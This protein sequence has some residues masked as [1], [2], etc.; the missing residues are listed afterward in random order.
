MLYTFSHCIQF[1]EKQNIKS[2]VITQPDLLQKP[3]ETV[4][5]TLAKLVNLPQPFYG[6]FYSAG[7]RLLYPFSDVDAELS[8]NRFSGRRI[9]LWH[10]FIDNNKVKLSLGSLKFCLLNNNDK[11]HC[12]QLLEQD[13]STFWFG[14]GCQYIESCYGIVFPHKKLNIYKSI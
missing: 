10:I 7:T 8:V 14:E 6:F 13:P 4:R 1:L 12:E 9:R 11:K 3:G 5:Q 2:E